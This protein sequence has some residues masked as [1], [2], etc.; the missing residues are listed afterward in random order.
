VIVKPYV[1]V[2]AAASVVLVLA[3]CARSIENLPTASPEDIERYRQ[4]QLDSRWDYIEESS[5]IER[6][7]IDMVRAIDDDEDWLPVM[8]ECMSAQGFDWYYGPGTEEEITAEAQNLAAVA[9]YI[10]AAKFPYV[11]NVLSTEQRSYL[12]D[13]YVSWLTPC[14]SMHGYL[15][16]N[17]P[18]KKEF[19]AQD[20]Y[21]WHPAQDLAMS[22]LLDE[23]G[24]VTDPILRQ[25]GYYPKFM[26]IDF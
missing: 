9:D 19:M 13:Y 1:R 15:V 23:E 10:C 16:K 12:Y 21:S 25:C 22:W 4:E 2:M 8:D 17:V 11:A 20:M 5:D 7:E 14:Y 3:G 26:G 6:P 18:S 24:H